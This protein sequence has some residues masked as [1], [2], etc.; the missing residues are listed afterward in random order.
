MGR[1]TGTMIH[2][3]SVITK[4]DKLKTFCDAIILDISE[5]GF[6]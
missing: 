4:M 1:T 2:Q 6:K 5:L 3:Y